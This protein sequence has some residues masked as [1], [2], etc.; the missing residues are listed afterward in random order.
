MLAPC[1]YQDRLFLLSDQESLKP[2]RRIRS[3]I[4]AIRTACSTPRLGCFPKEVHVLFAVVKLV[5]KT[6]IV[7]LQY[8]EFNPFSPMFEQFILLIDHLMML[9]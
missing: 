9:L 1:N 8:H 6:P 5:V 2:S 3:I 7:I 4:H